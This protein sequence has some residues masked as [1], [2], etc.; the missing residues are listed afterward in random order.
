MSKFK[1][2][3]RVS[4]K[5]LKDRQGV[6]T[7]IGRYAIG[8]Q[9]YWVKYDGCLETSSG[10]YERENDLKLIKDDEYEELKKDVEILLDV[11]LSSRIMTSKEIKRFS[12][13]HSDIIKTQSVKEIL[14]KRGK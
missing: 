2:G 7:S 3:D 14:K 12:E 10:D 6:I 4:H 11:Y 13:R 5:I 8:E 1:V 9:W